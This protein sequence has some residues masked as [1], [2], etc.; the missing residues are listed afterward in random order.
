MSRV[1]NGKGNFIFE[2]IFKHE[3]HSVYTFKCTNKK[4]HILTLKEYP[5]CYIK[6]FNKWFVNFKF[7][8]SPH[9]SFRYFKFGIRI[10]LFYF[11]KDNNNIYIGG[12]KRQLWIQTW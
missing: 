4:I 2:S 10:P 9:L 6:K 8:I 3:N 5:K 7:W 12:N 1:K 11:H